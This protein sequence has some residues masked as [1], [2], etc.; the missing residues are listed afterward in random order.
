MDK[1][2][3]QISFKELLLNIQEWWV[4]LWKKK[5]VIIPVSFVGAALGVCLAFLSEPRYEAE[6]TFVVEGQDQNPLSAYMGLASQF[7]LNMGGSGGVFEGDNIMEFLKSRLMVEQALMS[8]VKG[9]DANKKTLAELFIEI[10]E[11]RKEWE[12]KP[13]LK[14]VRFLVGESRENFT[15]LQDSILDRIHQKILNEYL[16][17]DK[18]DKKLSF[19]SAKCTSPNEVFSKQFVEQL[20]KEAILFYISTKTQKAKSNIDRLQGQSDSLRTLLNKKTYA[21]AATQD[22]NLN[23]ARQVAGVGVE[24]EM[25]DK[26]VLQTM[27]GEIVRNLELSKIAMSQETPVIQIVDRPIYPLPKKKLG[28]MKGLLIGGIAL[29]FITILVLILRKIFSDIFRTNHLVN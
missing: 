12:T 21:V 6:I 11:V 10:N 13:E 17:V 29:G 26:A 23:P 27:Y 15:R 8:P 7:G 14:N 3:D 5:W 25:R 16:S 9:P 19:I 20:V 18:P 28:K 4:Y 2:S 1:N 24:V 22:I